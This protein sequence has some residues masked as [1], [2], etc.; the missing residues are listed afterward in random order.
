[1]PLEL[2]VGQAKS[3][4]H[5]FVNGRH[6]TLHSSQEPPPLPQNPAQSYPEDWDYSKG[7]APPPVPHQRRYAGSMP[8]GFPYPGHPGE[9]RVRGP[10]EMW[11]PPSIR[12]QMEAGYLPEPGYG[13]PHMQYQ[14]HPQYYGPPPPYHWPKYSYEY[15]DNTPFSENRPQASR[16]PSKTSMGYDGAK[17]ESKSVQQQVS[18]EVQ[19]DDDEKQGL[20]AK[21]RELTQEV[22]RYRDEQKCLHDKLRI[23]NEEESRL[24]QL[25][26]EKNATI[27]QQ[28]IELT[29][30][31][32][33]FFS[34]YDEQ[35]T[36]SNYQ[37]QQLPQHLLSRPVSPGGSQLSY[38]SA[39]PPPHTGY[40]SI[41]PPQN[42]PN[43]GVNTP[44]QHLG[45]QNSGETPGAPQSDHG[46]IQM[47]VN[48]Y[49]SPPPVINLP[50][51]PQ[52]QA[53]QPG[54]YPTVPGSQPP[55]LPVPPGRTAQYN[56]SA[57]DSTY[58]G[59]PVTVPTPPGQPRS[60]S[61][62]RSPRW[63]PNA[64]EVPGAQPSTNPGVQDHQ[65]YHQ[66]QY[67]H[68]DTQNMNTRTKLGPLGGAPL[69]PRISGGSP[70]A[71]NRNSPENYKEHL[72]KS[73]AESW[74]Q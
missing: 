30:V 3:L 17:M 13:T 44:G 57:A 5:T 26:L 46:T 45:P 64:A 8:Y 7:A 16:Q 55:K 54:A 23:A 37:S 35:A 27:E 67:A 56:T 74:G 6:N 18:V 12:P 28:D 11:R 33:E 73:N 2:T 22:E 62:L 49:P 43:G 19:T 40:Q 4:V 59:N 61:P 24:Q 36:R 10:P 53:S 15:Y 38:Q 25:L 14:D 9:S 71:M 69:S 21:I 52:R 42:N 51:P 29:D 47:P 50:Q 58:T 60:Q 39:P 34:S 72:T 70:F 66:A 1:M 20:D 65:E 68:Q 63:Q 31:R 41:N 32:A 48:R